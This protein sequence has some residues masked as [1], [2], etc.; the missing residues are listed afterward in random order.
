MSGAFYCNGERE[1]C[2]NSSKC[3][4]NGG[5][6][7]YTDKIDYIA[8]RNPKYK[9][10]KTGEEMN[11]KTREKIEIKKTEVVSVIKIRAIVGSGT[12]ENPVRI[13]NHYWTPDGKFIGKLIDAGKAIVCSETS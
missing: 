6:C 1:E 7:Y 8:K 13:E 3:Y 4:K 5:S 2:K 11:G 10:H 9:N 12:P